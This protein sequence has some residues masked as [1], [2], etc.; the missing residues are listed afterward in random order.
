MQIMCLPSNKHDTTHVAHAIRPKK[1]RNCV[2]HQENILKWC[3]GAGFFYNELFVKTVTVWN[4]QLKGKQAW[5][6]QYI[7]TL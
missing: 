4:P 6:W 5:K 1:R 7:Y 2:S 3:G